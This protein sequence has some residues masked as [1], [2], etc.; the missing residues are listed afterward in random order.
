MKF[1]LSTYIISL[2]LF[3]IFIY[4]GDDQKA[5]LIVKI[6]GLK[7]DQGTVKVALCNS[8]ENYKNNRS[9]FKAAII[10][11]ENNQ[12]VAVFENLTPGSYAI[13]AF[14]DENDNDDFD[15]NF[16]GIPSEDYGFS[17]NVRGLFGPPSWDSAKFQLNKAEQIIEI[18]LH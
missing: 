9:P 11:I 5:K 6:T 7:N 16:L 18:N 17:N 4:A 15:T 8:K 13:K 2:L 1:Y 12:A 3:S 14:H 10:K